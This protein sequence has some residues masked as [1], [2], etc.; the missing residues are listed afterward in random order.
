MNDDFD[1]NSFRAPD[2]TA[3]ANRHAIMLVRKRSTNMWHIA[4]V[5]KGVRFN[6]TANVHIF[7]EY[8]FR[9]RDDALAAMK[10]AYTE[11]VRKAETIREK[12]KLM[13]KKS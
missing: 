13:D 1:E 12:V 7:E 2:P 10:D 11:I 8:K 5:P 4:F 3:V 6:D 9:Q